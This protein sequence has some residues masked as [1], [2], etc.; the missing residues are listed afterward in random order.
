MDET[1]IRFQPAE[2][3]GATDVS[4]VTIY[5]DRIIFQCNQNEMVHHFREIARPQIDFLNRLFDRVFRRRIHLNVVGEREFCT[6][7]RY[8]A[9]YTEPPLKIYLPP[10]DNEL[11]YSETY[12]Y[13]V[14]E[15]LG[16]GG[17]MT[18]DVS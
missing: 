9:F 16:A 18:W 17:Y 2:V 3:V 7:R 6:D 4:Q 1:F 8:V 5:S 10:E 12:F 11:R 15:I 13:K 14:N